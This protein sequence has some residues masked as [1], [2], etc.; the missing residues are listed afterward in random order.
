MLNVID[1]EMNDSTDLGGRSSMRDDRRFVVVTTIAPPTDAMCEICREAARFDVPVVVVGDL[2]S[3]PTYDA[4]CAVY[5]TI[6]GQ[7]D[8][9]PKLHE[10][11]PVN[12]YSRKNL[13]YLWAVRERR[14]FI[15]ETDDDNF[16]SAV[17]W[18]PLPKQLQVDLIRGGSSW[19]NAYAPF[20]GNGHRVWPRGLPLESLFE[21]DKVTSA[22]EQVI[23]P[24]IVQGLADDNPDVDAIYRM[25]RELP[26][27][28]TR[29]RPVACAAHLVSV[30][31]S[32][33]DFCEAIF[34]AALFALLLQ[35]SDDRHLA[36]VRGPEMSLG[37]RT[38]PDLHVSDRASGTERPQPVER[39]RGGNSWLPS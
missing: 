17:F 9:F 23:T 12:H 1:S 16:P 32:E 3:P 27:Q 31:Q 36:I 13:G 33:Y 37:G 2:K 39:L 20:L 5:L 8:C 11:L 4:P 25:T 29:R 21:S 15:Q 6:P 34:P 7:A 10:L 22:K 28:F 18:D 35:L 19:F 26:V 24:S 14:A 30:Q 38:L